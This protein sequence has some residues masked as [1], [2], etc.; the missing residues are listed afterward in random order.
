MKKERYDVAVIG[1]GVGGSCAAALL[2]DAGYKVL[3]AERLSRVGGRCSSEWIKG[4]MIDTGASILCGA[5]GPLVDIC[6]KVGAKF[7]VR[8]SPIPFYY[9][10]GGRNYDLDPEH[11]ES[12]AQILFAAAGNEEDPMR[13]L[14]A[15][16]MATTWTEPPHNITVADW[17]RQYTQ[18]QG[19]WDV[20]QVMAAANQGLNP[21]E[22][23]AGELLHLM[24]DPAGTGGAGY[25]YPVGGAIAPME[26]LARAIRDRGG[27]VWT[28]SPAKRI[29]VEAG[30]VKGVIVDGL[31]GEVEVVAQVVIS[32]AGPKATVELAGAEDFE[33][34]YRRLV[35]GIRPTPVTMI[36]VES[37]RP[38]L[39]HDGMAFTVGTRRMI[40]LYT[41]TLLCPEEAPPGK[42]LTVSASTPRPCSGR[43]SHKRELELH[44]QDFRE[45]VPDFDKYGKLIMAKTW[46]G[47]WPLYRAWAGR[48]LPQKTSVVNLYNVGDGTYPSG[49]IG[50]MGAARTGQVVAEDVMQRIKPGAN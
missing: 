10:M 32:N 18:N 13:V 38:L 2:A 34:G 11:P 9:R 48:C 39:D 25:G 46:R 33:L 24:T 6:R 41:P 4:Y 17:L 47:D 14:G 12:F 8:V 35:E 7:E 20:F 16:L 5:T 29:L 26:G 37:D 15:I 43:I 45:F 40:T 44:L 23:L 22:A 31:D 28:S 50:T 36:F 27:Q 21:N 49:W 42:H 30:A 3:V 19:I 1:S